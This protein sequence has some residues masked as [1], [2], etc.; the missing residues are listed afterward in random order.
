MLE[1]R[2]IV[3]VHAL[4]AATWETVETGF[5]DCFT[6]AQPELSEVTIEQGP[7]GRAQSRSLDLVQP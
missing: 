2:M 4:H 5:K 1:L 6:A 7:Q 3:A